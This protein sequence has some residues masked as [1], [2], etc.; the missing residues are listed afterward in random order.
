MTCRLQGSERARAHPHLTG[1]DAG[2]KALK[3]LSFHAQAEANRGDEDGK[4]DEKGA[5]LLQ[6][7]DG[8]LRGAGAGNLGCFKG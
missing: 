1:A 6:D 2:A 4:R 7:M 8:T 3:R 5:K